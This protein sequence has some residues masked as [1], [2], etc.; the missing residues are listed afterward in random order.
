MG[1]PIL[2]AM[3]ASKD[4]KDFAPLE[5]KSR[6]LEKYYVFVP[7]KGEVLVIYG[8]SFPDKFER[9]LAKILCVQ[10]KDTR[11]VQNP[12]IITYHDKIEERP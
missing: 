2:A 9:V 10:L 12:P 3:H 4:G 6:A 11:A 7:N 1:A 8:L 5:I